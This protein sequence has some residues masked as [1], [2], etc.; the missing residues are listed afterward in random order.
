MSE[1][2]KADS[3]AIQAFTDLYDSLTDEQKEKTKACKTAG[4]LT[5][6][7]SQLGVALPDEMLDSVAGG[8]EQ[9]DLE[10]I[11]QLALWDDV[12]RQRGI[13]VYD[14]YNRELVWRELFP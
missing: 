3:K 14:K 5:S 8:G 2:K 11:T 1:N 9:E 4:E 7:L 13:D 12:C 10:F 6:L